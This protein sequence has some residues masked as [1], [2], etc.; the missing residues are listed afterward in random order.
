MPSANPQRNELGEF[1]KARRAELTPRDVGLPETGAIRRV[2]G[3]RREEVAQL[4]S[5]S[6]DYYTRLE[7][8]RL[9][10]SAPVLASLARVLRL[11]PDQCTYLHA[12]AG[13][14]K[15]THRRRGDRKVSPALERLLVGLAET[16]AYI[17]NR[18]MD[19][20]AW[21][22]LAA[23]LIT[24]FGAIP[25][26]RRN[27]VRLVFTD[28][29][30]R[31]LYENWHVS[32]RT[33]VSALRMHAAENPEDPELAKLVGDLSVQDED[34]RK[35]WAE[36]HVAVHDSG[37]KVVRHPVVGDITVDWDSLTL[38]ADPGQRLVFWTADPD[39]PSHD[40]LL[41]LASWA[42]AEAEPAADQQR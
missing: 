36:H 26:N 31:E 39:S 42:S 3:L 35:W 16:P 4:A 34:F 41:I 14:R 5:I 9:S 21:N 32:A 12:V 22:P 13:K 20:L 30:M 11:N 10:A 28:P 6:T 18:R 1:L 25:E 7:Q 33:T 8:G 37:T 2:P 19:I 40:K 17:V 38:S 23:A 24:D 15:S 29:R 27:Y